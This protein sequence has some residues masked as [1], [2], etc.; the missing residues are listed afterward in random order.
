[1]LE[2]SKV[3]AVV[4]TFNRK[5]LLFECLDSLL[6]MDDVDSIYLV[7]NAS[8]DGTKA[9]LESKGYLSNGKI[10][11]KLL[12]SNTGGAGGFHHALKWA[13]EDSSSDW[14]WMMDDDVEPVQ[15]AL[16]HLLK[17]SGFSKCIHPTKSFVGGETYKWNGWFDT[18]IGRSIWLD[19]R[20][21][22]NGKDFTVVNYGCFEGMLIHREIISKI[23]FPDHRFFI[24]DDDL[25]YGLL[26]S[27]YTNVLYIKEIGL[28]KKIKK[29]NLVTKFGLASDRP[30]PFH[31]YFNVRNHFLV[32]DYLVEHFGASRTKVTAFMWL[33]IIKKFMESILFDLP[34]TD[35][36]K[37]AWF[38]L[39]DGLQRNFEGHKKFI[40]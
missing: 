40:S 11:Y 20:F 32:A 18:E 36:L 17:Y 10:R 24:H 3:S 31:Q 16:V 34:K 2:S 8:T 25:I 30:T 9:D 28:I 19:E 14:F 7:D 39:R 22:E 38:G 29:Q 27:I 15:D 23:G 12:D 4:V 1:M 37:M 26:A 13:Y 33:K 35:S 5:A 6:K 21:R